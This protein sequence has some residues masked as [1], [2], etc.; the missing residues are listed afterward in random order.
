MSHVSWRRA[1]A[2]L[3]QTCVSTS[4]RR[5]YATVGADR[6]YD[7]ALQ[8][9]ES[10]RNDVRTE[11]AELERLEKDGKIAEK[12]HSLTKKRVELA[13]SDLA[14]HAAFAS[15]KVDL[16]KDVF[17]SMHHRR[18]RSFLVP[19]LLKLEEEHRV[20]GDALPARIA[21]EVNF[22]VNFQNTN[23]LCPYGQ[24]VP[25]VWTLYSPELIIT[26]GDEK[27]RH[28]T[29][30]LVDLDRP[31]LETQSYEEWCHWLVTDI[32]VQNRLVIPGGSSPLLQPASDSVQKSLA[33]A[34]FV[35]S[36]PAQEPNIPGNVIFPYVP[37]H[38]PA[39]NPRKVH[40]YFFAVLEQ[41]E[42]SLKIDIESVKQQAI[43]MA[44]QLKK[45]EG[46]KDIPMWQKSVEGEGEKK[47]MVRERGLLFPT[48]KFIKQ[49][50]LELKGHGFF[51][52]GWDIHTPAVFSRLGIHEPVYGKIVNQTPTETVRQLE[53][54]TELAASLPAPLAS[55]STQALRSLNYAERP[56]V[57][58]ARL[59]TQRGLEAEARRKKEA[60]AARKKGK[61]EVARPPAGLKKTPRLTALG[62]AAMVRTKDGDIAQGYKGEL[63][64]SVKD[65][66]YRYKN[67]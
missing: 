55:L 64:R 27:L 49:Y 44:E 7:L 42:P 33:G 63:V 28:F 47:L 51:T 34:T 46:K 52:A 1:P 59:A 58:P 61:Q 26:T 35:P 41:P 37:A 22:E 36:Q 21:P 67:V 8:V 57:A 40:R 56:R 62:A 4:F 24:P 17:A 25:P 15:G 10:E 16:A 29:I 19:Q 48:T 38:P 50:G 14:N 39:S 30:A 9:L 60:G 23:W 12:E 13:Y 20:I 53:T 65:K 31:E 45:E 66:R 5:A 54:A 2:L 11:I 32:P 43:A 6:A 3:R 18:W